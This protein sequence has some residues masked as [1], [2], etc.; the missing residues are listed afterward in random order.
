MVSKKLK[1]VVPLLAV[2]LIAAL[3]V[4]LYPRCNIIDPY[5]HK[6]YSAT[7]VNGLSWTVNNTMIF[8]HASVPGAVYFNSRLYLYFVKH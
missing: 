2:G 7:S 8:D 6:I 3:V 4:V 5:Y 1:I